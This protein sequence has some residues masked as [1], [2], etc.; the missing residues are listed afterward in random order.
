MR[1]CIYIGKPNALTHENPAIKGSGGF[2][3]AKKT[4]SM[5]GFI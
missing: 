1:K 3:Q 5:A 4:R 2:W